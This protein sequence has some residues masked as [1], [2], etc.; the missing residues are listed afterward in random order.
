M[1]QKLTMGKML[2][3]GG[4]SEY[5][6]YIEFYHVSQLIIQPGRKTV[7]A[8]LSSWWKRHFVLIGLPCLVVR[9]LQNSVDIC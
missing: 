9:V 3:L 8:W 5:V 7:D 6:S 2:G 4:S 1:L